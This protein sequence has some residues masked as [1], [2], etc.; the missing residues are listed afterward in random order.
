MF[1]VFADQACTTNF[2]THEFNIAER[3]LFHEIKSAK[4]F[5]QSAKVY[6]FEIYPL[7]G[8]YDMN[9]VIKLQNFQGHSQCKQ[10]LD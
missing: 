3:L 9:S 1:A 5:C 4:T 6:T 8:N 2:Y 7:Y 10:T